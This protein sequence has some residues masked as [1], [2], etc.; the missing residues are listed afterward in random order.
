MVCDP[1]HIDTFVKADL[2][3]G[4]CVIVE[5]N[6]RRSPRKILE[7]IR[8]AG[9]TLVYAVCSVLSQEGDAVVQHL[10]D[11][12]P[13]ARALP[14]NASWGEAH[15]QGRRLPPGGDFDGFYFARIQKK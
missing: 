5:D 1:R 6:G 15:G 2:T 14:I 12:Q 9:G 3:P 7:A 10:L 8:D 11:Q 13:S 4:T